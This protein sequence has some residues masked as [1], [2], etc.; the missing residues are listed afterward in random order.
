MSAIYL[1]LSLKYSPRITKL[2]IA[3]TSKETRQGLQRLTQMKEKNHKKAILATMSLKNF[4]IN[5][6]HYIL[7]AIC[8][9]VI[10]TGGKLEIGRAHV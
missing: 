7:R 10:V 6:I 2:N 4:Y 9:A 3:T 8:L 5:V 1:N